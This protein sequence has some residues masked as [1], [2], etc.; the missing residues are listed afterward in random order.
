[1]LKR[2]RLEAGSLGKAE[3]RTIVDGHLAMYLICEAGDQLKG[4]EGYTV[5][6]GLAELDL[7]PEILETD[8]ALNAGNEPV[9]RDDESES[10]VKVE[11]EVEEEVAEGVAEGL[12]DGAMLKADLQA[13]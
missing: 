8:D 12:L 1:M 11:I 9:G 13:G 6:K 3:I 10:E 7:K 2:A 5:P 4:G